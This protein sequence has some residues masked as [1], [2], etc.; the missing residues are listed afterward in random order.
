MY[1][2]DSVELDVNVGGIL[3]LMVVKLLVTN[4]LMHLFCSL[5][6]LA[7]TNTEAILITQL[8]TQ[9]RH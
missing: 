1:C 2:S 5:V 4:R 3:M 9:T 6:S 8:N 7:N